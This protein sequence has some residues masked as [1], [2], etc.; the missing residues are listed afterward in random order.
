LTYTDRL[1]PGGDSQVRT[2]GEAKAFTR[3]LDDVST[4]AFARLP[5]DAWFCPAHGDDSDRG[6]RRA[7]L[8]EWRERGW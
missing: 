2:L 7:H 4:K 6:L 3:I 5:E 8:G 1:K